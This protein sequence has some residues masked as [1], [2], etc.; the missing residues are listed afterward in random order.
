M[1]LQNGENFLQLGEEQ[2][3]ADGTGDELSELK[4]IETKEG[5][6]AFESVKT[7][8]RYISVGEDGSVQPATEL[9][10]ST[11]F[12]P[13]SAVKKEEPEPAAAEQT[14]QQETSAENEEGKTEE[15]ATEQKE[16][17]GQVQQ[18]EADEQA[19]TSES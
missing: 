13:Y 18:K 16:E 1:T 9:G 5:C 19:E 11:N 3:G 4:V 14:E 6:V 17:D 8:G 15:T 10:A 2:V 12:T 7:A